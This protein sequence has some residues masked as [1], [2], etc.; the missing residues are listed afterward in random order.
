MIEP[1]EIDLDS[2]VGAS[3]SILGLNLDELAQAAVSEALKGLV[4]QA[5]LILDH[6]LR[7]EL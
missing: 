5:A 6:P 2:F 7:D 1:D 3:A 4:Q